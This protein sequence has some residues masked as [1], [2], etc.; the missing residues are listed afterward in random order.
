MLRMGVS[1]FLEAFAQW[2]HSRPDI[3][4]VA[5]VGSYARGAATEG[6]DVDLVI[7]TSVVDRYL[8][9]RSW[10]SMFGE[11]AESHEEDYGRV[12]SVRVCYRSG[13]EVEYGFTTPDWADT[14]VDE[15]TLSVVTNG[16]KVLHDP[17]GIIARMQQE[18]T[19]NVK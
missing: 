14:P 10:V 7:L 19:S 11:A 9:D 18:M 1:A 8:R 2:G 5:L 6:S 16:M 12:K 13:L 3:D 17:H 15:G 4:G